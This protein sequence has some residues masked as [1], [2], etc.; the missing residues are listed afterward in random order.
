MDDPFIAMSTSVYLE[1]SEKF[2]EHKSLLEEN[3]TFKEKAIN[4]GKKGF[5][6][7]AGMATRLATQGGVTGE[8]L[9]AVGDDLAKKSGDGVTNYLRSKF[10]NNLERDA[11]SQFREQLGGTGGCCEKFTELSSV[12]RGR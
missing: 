6:F 10:E 11:F 7:T 1:V 4:F 9:G 8:D 5:A 2:K 3:E 12:G